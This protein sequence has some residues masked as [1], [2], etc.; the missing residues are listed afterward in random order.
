[1]IVAER[2]AGIDGRR[3]LQL[4]LAEL[5]V[6]PVPL[7]PTMAER[8]HRAWRRYGKGRRR[9]RLNLGDCFSY[10]AAQHL[11]APLLH[12]GEDFAHTDIASD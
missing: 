10:A 2:K 12:K 5:S 6:Q 1:M 7:T 9:T 8:A 11:G 3:D 4:L